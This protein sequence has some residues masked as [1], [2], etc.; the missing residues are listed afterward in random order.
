MLE[1][2]DPGVRGQALA[3]DLQSLLNLTADPEAVVGLGMCSQP[4]L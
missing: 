4:E 3:K 1:H 2:S